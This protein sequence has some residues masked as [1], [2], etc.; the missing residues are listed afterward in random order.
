MQATGVP[1]SLVAVFR[2]VARFADVAKART[3]AAPRGLDRPLLQLAAALTFHATGGKEL[4]LQPLLRNRRLAV[5]AHPVGPLVEAPERIVDL[6]QLAPL[7][8]QP[9]ELDILLEHRDRTVADLDLFVLRGE[10][11]LL[12]PPA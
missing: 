8:L 2:L 11:G 3:K 1:H 4:N 5:L 12:D 10:R 9:T 7:H 6:A